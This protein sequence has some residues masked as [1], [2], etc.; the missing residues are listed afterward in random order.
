[1]L[2]KSIKIF[3]PDTIIFVVG[4]AGKT[5]P[6]NAD[7]TIFPMVL[8]PTS[9][10]FWFSASVTENLYKFPKHSIFPLALE[11]LYFY[12]HLKVWVLCQI[13]EHS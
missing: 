9:A 5:I 10:V 13:Y 3:A 8:F 12:F 11:L 4:A 6:K 2:L 1:M 7:S